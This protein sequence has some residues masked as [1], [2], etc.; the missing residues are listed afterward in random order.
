MEEKIFNQIDG[1]FFV[2]TL[3]NIIRSAQGYVPSRSKRIDEL[4]KY[5]YTY[6]LMSDDYSRN[7]YL[8]ILSR[9]LA[10]E[11]LDANIARSAFPIWSEEFSKQYESSRMTVSL[12]D[13]KH[14]NDTAS[15]IIFPETFYLPAYEYMDICTVKENETVFDIGA[16]IGDTAYVFSQ[17]M[18]GTGRIYA[19]E[20]MPQNF[21]MLSENAEKIPNLIINNI[22]LGKENG[23]IKFSFGGDN[24]GASRQNDN[25][26]FEVKVTTVD[27]YVRENNIDRVDFIKADIEGAE[28]DMLLGAADT[29]R[30][31]H[32]K[33]AICI[34]HRGQAD[35]YK[36]PQV[37]QS[38]RQDY[39]FYVEAYQNGLN[40]TV[41]F[42][43]PVNYI[44]ERKSS[45][46][47]I[48]AIKEM[49]I[50]VHDK[51]SNDYQS[52]FFKEFNYSL[53]TYLNCHFNWQINDNNQKLLLKS[54]RTIHYK[55]F[56]LRNCMTVELVFD[57]FGCYPNEHKKCILDILDNFFKRQ[58][59]YKRFET[60]HGLFI[61]KE[62]PYQSANPDDL[63]CNMS[64]LIKETLA[65]LW[66]NGLVDPECI[67][68][69]LYNGGSPA[70]LFP[71]SAK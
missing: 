21:E 31:F 13:L 2:S 35:H 38:I 71:Y 40:E 15:R 24:S 45:Y 46:A 4:E 60:Q 47:G 18:R 9:M 33:L 10:N 69:L 26:T 65:R 41:L 49:Y 54:N 61:R 66:E 8:R 16:W 42:A 29:I 23:V 70:N 6:S 62:I 7:L 55:V 34:Y 1:E 37:I 51:L 39:E 59:D 25:G 44:P 52:S 57:N 36:V 64:V 68:P 17:R 12:P 43:V 56:F 11:F 28:C 27:C 22:A 50:A 14:P 20:P 53:D 19:F 63:A 3:T 5:L 48:K 30:K 32:P 58:S 67:K